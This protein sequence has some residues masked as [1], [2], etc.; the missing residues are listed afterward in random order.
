MQ[1]LSVSSQ[2]LEEF[3][4]APFG[5]K[6][7]V[8]RTKY[9]S[10]YQS[11]ANSNK[12]KIEGTMELNGDYFIHLKVPS[13]SAKGDVEY[14]V[15]V[16]FFTTD[17]AKAKNLNV[18][19]YFVQFFSNSPGFIYKYAALYKL[20]GYLIESL[21]D[22]FD[23]GSLDILPDKANSK[24][25]MSYDSTIFYAC[26]Y[27]LDNRASVLGKLAMKSLKHKSPQRFFADIQDTEEM[28]LSRDIS[29]L[30]SEIKKD[31]G[32]LTD[33]KIHKLLSKQE[34][35]FGEEISEKKKRDIE[36][37]KTS[38]KEK[39]IRG[40]KKIIAAQSTL[41]QPGTK[42]IRKKGKKTAT[43]STTKK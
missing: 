9:E 8:K 19:K 26:R 3:L 41:T 11:Y 33:T 14:D 7:L 25:E 23:K 17:E 42:T 1:P 38:H 24:Y 2:T 29:K 31:R 28:Q 32:R 40:L 6:D 16:Q 5:I 27:L 20:Q 39:K 30:E 21:Y 37:S 43:K 35:V 12:I 22:K 34:D 4:E 13:E 36:R 10:R 18:Q 15:V